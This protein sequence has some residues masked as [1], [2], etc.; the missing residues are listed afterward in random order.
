MKNAEGRMQSPGQTSCAVPGGRAV[1]ARFLDTQSFIFHS[2]RPTAIRA[3]VLTAI[4]LG[5]AVPSP[6]DASDWSHWRGADQNGFSHEYGTVKKWSLDG[7]NLLWKSP[8]GGRSTPLVMGGR[9]YYIAP[10]GD[11]ACLQERVI[12]LDADT[13]KTVWDYRFNVFFSDIVAQR[14]GWTALAA[15]PETGNLYAHGTGGQFICLSK[16]G[17]LIWQHSLTEE[18]NR[19]SGYGGRLMTP[20]VDEDRVIVSFLNTNWG[21]HAKPGHRFVAFNKHDGSVVWWAEPG[22]PPVDTTY[23]T[24]IVMVVDGRRLLVAP[25]GDGV[26]YG[27][28]ARTGKV[29]WSYALSKLGLNVSPVWVGKHVFI[30]HSEENRDSTVMGRLV[31]IDASKTGDITQSGEVWRIDGLDAGYASLAYANGRVYAVDNSATLFAVDAVAGK[32]AWKYKLGRV[33]KGSPV[34]TADNVIYVGEQNGIFCILKDAGAHCQL[35]SR[36]EFAPRE[37][38]A[39]DELY[40]SPAVCGGRV[41]FMTRY[42]MYCLADKS[43]KVQT[44]DATPQPKETP[45]DDMKPATIQI[46][47]ADVTLMPGG[48]QKFEVRAFNSRGVPT[49]ESAGPLE[50]SLTSNLR[51]IVSQ[52]GTFSAM[53]KIPF[54]AGLLTVSGGGL[55]TEARVR[56]SPWLPINED[57]ERNREGVPPGGWI[58]VGGKTRITKHDGSMV[59]QKLAEK[60]KPSPVWKMR[61][62][63]TMPIPGGYTVEADL[64]GTLARKRFR[65]D[66]GVINSRYELIV[67]GMQKELELARWRDEPTHALRKRIPFELKENAWYRFKLRVELAGP[68]AL[69]RGKVW[70]R[71]E[72]EPKDW[73]IEFEDTCP[74]PEGSPGIFVYSNGTTDKSDGAEVYIDNFKVLVN[75]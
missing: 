72:A 17:K 2:P 36:Q 27:M 74:N 16:D 14:V 3:M 54:T 52:D 33:G 13:G 68:K 65:P 41:Y 26:V 22:G 34:V 62:Y 18:Y 58:G 59:F 40:G 51:G 12:C 61:A 43:A 67:L 31:C 29:V 64:Q 1:A 23:G 19:V 37:G 7:E 60:G 55:S 57:F 48:R 25:C 71:D 73:T 46:V 8:E 9:V 75:Q 24:P 56:V 15:D 35:L 49:N 11:G 45:G 69:V 39:I 42:G 44:A 47:P 53:D 63:A 38:G 21:N 6:V 30:S 32:V 20:I 5:I 10:A 4:A 28:E 50:W 70:L 66:M